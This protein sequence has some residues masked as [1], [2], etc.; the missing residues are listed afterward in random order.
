MDKVN[1]ICCGVDV[2][3][4]LIVACLRKGNKH[5]VR[6]FVATTI[7]LLEMANWLK[8]SGRQTA[9]M[10]AY[11]KYY[12]GLKSQYNGGQRSP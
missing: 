10:K 3:I 2:H 8:Q 5:E 4:K 6:K 11:V 1:D 9:A 12:G 7:E